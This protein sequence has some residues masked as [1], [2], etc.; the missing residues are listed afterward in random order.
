MGLQK[1]LTEL[2]SSIR[3]VIG[4]SFKDARARSARSAG[5]VKKVAP[6]TT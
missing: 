3:K 2:I 6:I 5:R 1:E 4:N